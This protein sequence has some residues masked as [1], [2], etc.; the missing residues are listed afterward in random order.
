MLVEDIMIRQV[1][2]VGPET[3]VLEA[4][5]LAE[6]MRVRHLPVVDDGRLIGIIS[7]RDLRDVK[8]SIMEIDDLAILS[9]TRVKDI[10]HTALITVHPLDAI[11][12]AAKM[13]YDHRIGCLPVVQ[14]GKLVGIIT[15]TDL[16]HAIVDMMGMGQPGSYL[17]IEVPDRPGALFDLATIVKAHGVNIISI[18]VNP[19]RQGGRRVISLRIATFDPRQIIQEIGEAGYA[20]VFPIALK[21]E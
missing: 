11:E 6:R 20:V 16:L 1:H 14:A 17:E 7:D 9:S 5:T 4:L 3:T 2:V 18:F 13:L 21:G 15:T 8:P 12:D 19:A 10:V